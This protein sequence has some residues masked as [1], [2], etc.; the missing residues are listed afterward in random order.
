MVPRK[1]TILLSGGVLLI[2]I[3]ILSVILLWPRGPH[4]TIPTVYTRERV[5]IGAESDNPN[6]T[7]YEPHGLAIDK[8]GNLYVVDSYN[9]RIVVYDS[10]GRFI[11][12]IGRAGQGPG[13]FIVPIDADMDSLGRLYVLEARNYR[14]S[15]FD[16][17]GNFLNSFRV[18]PV[19]EDQQIA[20]TH[21]G[22]RICVNEPTP[23]SGKLFTVY[24]NT[25]EVIQRFGE[26]VTPEI[27][28]LKYEMN[29]VCFDFDHQGN[30]YV[31]FQYRP[32]IRKYGPK[33]ELILQKPL[34]TFEVK[35]RM[36]DYRSLL[37]Q[38]PQGGTIL[39]IGDVFFC[40]NNTLLVCAG[41]PTRWWKRR[42]CTI[43]YQFDTNLN[44]LKRIISD[45]PP[46]AKT[47]TY[48]I[49]LSNTGWVW[50]TKM[51]SCTLSKIAYIRE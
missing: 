19:S 42:P 27:R 40:P 51:L 2:A 18:G 1:R 22:K 37:K 38:Y 29:T 12:E 24:N 14:V 10:L 21:D 15:I 43:L 48:S 8:N 28:G 30:L 11:R 34:V 5:I 32:E 25:G 13:E 26:L 23:M 17:R 9:H 3:I 49:V 20:V 50:G 41:I 7:L 31:F 6:Y 47:G 44:P 46:E 36:Q 45:A 4:L 33:G 16:E 35:E 39:F